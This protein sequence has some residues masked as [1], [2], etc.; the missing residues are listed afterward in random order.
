MMPWANCFDPKNLAK[1][2]NH[3]STFNSIL[4]VI[5][6][7]EEGASWGVDFPK[8]NHTIFMSAKFEQNI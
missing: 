1:D 8:E 2:T 4:Q 7:T 3:V 6:V 5:L